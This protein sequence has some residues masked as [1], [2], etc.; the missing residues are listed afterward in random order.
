[1]KRVHLP[2]KV[3]GRRAS[4]RGK[5]VWNWIACHFIP[6]ALLSIWPCFQ[7]KAF[8][9]QHPESLRTVPLANMQGQ[10]RSAT[11]KPASRVCRF[12]S[13]SSH[14]SGRLTFSRCFS[15]LTKAEQK[16]IIDTY[17][18]EQVKRLCF[19]LSDT[20]RNIGDQLDIC[21]GRYLKKSVTPQMSLLIPVVFRIVKSW[22]LQKGSTVSS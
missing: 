18:L 10:Y 9:M 22:S 3:S 6:D 21:A 17:D 12:A 16:E 2:A 7:K 19:I 15:D 1:M 5:K 14:N 8:P 11:E 20:L 4:M 13:S